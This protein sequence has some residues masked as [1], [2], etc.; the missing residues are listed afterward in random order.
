MKTSLSAK[1]TSLT[2]YYRTFILGTRFCKS[3]VSNLEKNLLVLSSLAIAS[4]NGSQRSSSFF[5]KVP[6]KG[7]IIGS[8]IEPQ[9][10]IELR[11]I[12]SL[13]AI[14]L[15]SVSKGSRRIP[16][17]ESTKALRSAYLQNLIFLTYKVCASSKC[18]SF[19]KHI[20]SMCLQS[21]IIAVHVVD[22]S[23]FHGSTSSGSIPF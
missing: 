3:E 13:S 16:K 8:K 20:A 9:S 5:Q 19:R 6:V 17:I 1:I 22:L 12:S 11:I 4:R 15:R 18:L 21:L 10:S 2:E 14:Y 7:R 23:L